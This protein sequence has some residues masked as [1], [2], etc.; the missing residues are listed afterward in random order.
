MGIIPPV[1]QGHCEGLLRTYIK[2]SELYQREYSFF[3]KMMSLCIW[4]PLFS[5]E[6][7]YI[8]KS[9]IWPHPPWLADWSKGG[10]WLTLG[11]C[12]ANL[13]FPAISGPCTL[14]KSWNLSRAEAK[15]L[16]DCQ[17]PRFLPSRES[18]TEAREWSWVLGAWSPATSLL[19][20]GLK[21]VQFSWR[22]HTNHLRMLLILFPS[23]LSRLQFLSPITARVLTKTLFPRPCNWTSASHS[24]RQLA[25]RI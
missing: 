7:L 12:E 9:F 24:D 10:N 13:P 1:S 19:L 2:C 4:Y 8:S 21:L 23:T 6:L 20:L 22:F 25:S 14:G 11:Q 15:S 17:Q 3:L 16:E 18:Q 5:W